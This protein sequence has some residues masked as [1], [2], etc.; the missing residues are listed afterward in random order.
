MKTQTEKIL[1]HYFDKIIAA[2]KAI[3]KGDVFVDYNS[4]SKSVYLSVSFKKSEASDIIKDID[5]YLTKTAFFKDTTVSSSTYSSFMSRSIYAKPINDILDENRAENLKDL[6]IEID[7]YG[8]RN[9][10]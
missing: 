8:N 2:V 7:G 1:N 6:L 5:M 10:T 3:G 4:D 9:N